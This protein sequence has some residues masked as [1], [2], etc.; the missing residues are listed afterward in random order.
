[1]KFLRGERRDKVSYSPSKFWERNI[2]DI[3]TK[4]LKRDHNYRIK[5]KSRFH[6]HS[7]IDSV[8]WFLLNHT[9]SYMVTDK[10]RVR[11]IT[12]KHPDLL[13][14]VMDDLEFR[15]QFTKNRYHNEHSPSERKDSGRYKTD[16]FIFLDYSL[17][18]NVLDSCGINRLLQI[19][20]R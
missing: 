9:N 5:I 15:E 4:K 12:E 14:R 6:N 7:V 3:Y 19:E 13:G 10:V 16:M 1:M 17:S 2:M 8:L 11:D 20:Y 18:D